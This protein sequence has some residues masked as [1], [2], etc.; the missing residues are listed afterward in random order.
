MIE[1][2]PGT[3]E[4]TGYLAEMGIFPFAVLL[5]RPSVEDWRQAL[6]ESQAT[7]HRYG[8]VAV[9]DMAATADTLAAWKS[10]ADD[11]ELRLRVDAALIMND[12]LADEKEPYETV[13]RLGQ[14]KSRLLDPMSVKWIGDGTPLTARPCCWSPTRMPPATSA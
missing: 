3:G 9:T 10:I 14:F 6:L 13:T 7:Y 1:K 2:D 5:E 8:I 4:P 12:Y 11:G